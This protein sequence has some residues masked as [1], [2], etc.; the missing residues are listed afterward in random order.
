[1]NGKR[2]K[3]SLRRKNLLGKPDP[4]CADHARRQ[5]VDQ[6]GC[7]DRGDFGLFPPRQARPDNPF[8]VCRGNDERKAILAAVE[9]AQVLRGFPIACSETGALEPRPRARAQQRGKDLAEPCRLESKAAERC[10]HPQAS[11]ARI[12][13]RD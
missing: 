7:S 11:P 3:E 10:A 8:A 5:R 12:R 4:R 1:M 2:R 13:R 9:P 6:L